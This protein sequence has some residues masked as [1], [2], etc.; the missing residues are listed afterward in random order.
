MSEPVPPLDFCAFIEKY[1]DATDKSALE[2]SVI[3]NTCASLANS[4]ITLNE[5]FNAVYFFIDGVIDTTDAQSFLTFAN[6]TFVNYTRQWVP[7]QYGTLIVTIIVIVFFLSLSGYID[8]PMAVLIALG[9]ASFLAVI[10]VVQLSILD[11][12]MNERE[13]TFQNLITN[14]VD[15]VA[16]AAG[17]EALTAYID[18]SQLTINNNINDGPTK[19]ESLT[20]PYDVSPPYQR[21]LIMYT[22]TPEDASPQ[23]AIFPVRL[24]GTT[25]SADLR[26]QNSLVIYIMNANP[27][28]EGTFGTFITENVSPDTG[29]INI[30]NATPSF[31]ADN[32]SKINLSKFLQTPKNEGI[33]VLIHPGEVKCFVN[34]GVNLVRTT[35]AAGDY[36]AVDTWVELTADIRPFQQKLE[37]TSSGSLLPTHRVE[38]IF[39]DED[40]VITINN[41]YGYDGQELII[42][43]NITPTTGSIW[44]TTNRVGGTEPGFPVIMTHLQK[45]VLQFQRTLAT[46]QDGSG[47]LIISGPN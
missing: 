35:P 23:P 11:D 27:F 30:I 36:L 19:L 2:K 21:L 15:T 40:L 7:F 38:N 12:F 41:E 6:T 31:P 46:T 34:V 43:A 28:N 13:T 47:W 10:A 37:Y 45:L 16:K 14:A 26:L 20:T 24:S 33:G 44:V 17:T 3:K 9:S 18:A 5:L 39:A 42:V 22:T 1:I 25:G 32:M 8:Y 29:I 4:E